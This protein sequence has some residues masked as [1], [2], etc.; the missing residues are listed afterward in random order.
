MKRRTFIGGASAAALCMPEI[1]TA[2]KTQGPLRIAFYTDLHLR[3]EWQTPDAWKQAAQKINALPADIAICGGDMITDGFDAAADTLEPR[4][5]V[6]FE[7]RNLIKKDVY[8]MIG[9]HGLVGAIPADGS[10]PEKDPRRVFKEKMK[11]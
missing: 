8:T 4:W 7:G 6:Y 11:L 5:Q 9:N 10:A 1:V 3:T 2:R